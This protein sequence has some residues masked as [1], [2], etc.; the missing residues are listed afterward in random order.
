[1]YYAI[2][3]LITLIKTA[4]FMAGV[5][6]DIWELAPYTL[7]LWGN[8][9]F[10]T[11]LLWSPLLYTD[12]R[13]WTYLVCILLD[14]WL[15]GNLVY[16]RSYG[17]F[18]NRWC[19]LNTGN[20]AGLWGAV[21]PFLRYSDLGF[22]AATVVWVI[23]SEWCSP[24]GWLSRGKQCLL[25]FVILILSCLPQAVSSLQTATPIN[26]FSRYYADVSMGRFW[27]I[28]TFGPL[29][30]FAN[31][32][33]NLTFRR[34]ESAVPV[35]QQEIQPFLMPKDT[36]AEQTANLLFVFF[37]SWEYW[38]VGLKVGG[39]EVTPNIN[40]LITHPSTSCYPMRAQVKEGKSS[41][42]QLIA[43]CGLLPVYNGAVS[44]RYPI[45]IYPAW[46]RASH[47]RTK[48]LFTPCEP[49]MWNQALLA[50]S[51]GFDSLYAEEVSDIELSRRVCHS[52]LSSSP[53][54][55]IAMT[56]MGSHSPFMTYAD[57]ASLPR[58][59]DYTQEQQRY[60]QCVHYTDSALGQ[61]FEQ[62]LSDSVLSATTR[63]VITGDHPI[64]EIDRPVPFVIYDPLTPPEE[65]GHDLNQADIYAVITKRTGIA[66]GWKGLGQAITD[67]IQVQEDN[68][69][70]LS[71]R[72]I[73]TDYFRHS[74][75]YRDDE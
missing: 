59:T 17:D 58:Q 16:F 30:H 67:S 3:I 72:I 31:E 33:L 18:L 45:N 54:W 9:A 74:P 5:G 8:Y 73:R 25:A 26:P 13:R 71:D 20:M 2:I 19:L 49:T 34:E 62:I 40:R 10:Y 66:T 36:T 68:L 51:W 44:M 46:V 56:T 47:A 14:I 69:F 64:F 12:R 22:I 65:P 41:D 24:R 35:S 55:L 48:Q 15:I 57:S 27:Y 63:I 23:C 21:L 53:Q 60:L 7:R 43:F 50:S 38:T 52:V 11:L 70:S 39:E 42:A 6:A 4:L 29:A 61:I 37:E 28:H 1:M 75:V 32:L